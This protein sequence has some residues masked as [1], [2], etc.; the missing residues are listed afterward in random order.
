MV[1]YVSCVLGFR[2]VDGQSIY[3]GWQLL[4]YALSHP[5]PDVACVH[6]QYVPSLGRSCKSV[7]NKKELKRKPPMQGST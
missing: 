4:L 3:L 2:E 1:R 5:F 6:E 7:V